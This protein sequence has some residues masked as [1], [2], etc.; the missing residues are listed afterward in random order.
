MKRNYYKA[1]Y[2]GLNVAAEYEIK[3]LSFIV[4]N[5]DS[6]ACSHTYY[7]MHVPHT[8]IQMSRSFIKFGDLK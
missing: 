4:R 1:K 2:T 6:F 7:T 8:L 5:E 3:T